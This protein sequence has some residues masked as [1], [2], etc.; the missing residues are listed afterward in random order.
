MFPKVTE[1][2]KRRPAS[3]SLFEGDNILEFDLQRW[4][5]DCLMAISKSPSPFNVM[6]SSFL[7]TIVFIFSYL[8][9]F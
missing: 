6:V 3:K 7:L 8:H 9:L 4:T 5:E 2:M 1:E